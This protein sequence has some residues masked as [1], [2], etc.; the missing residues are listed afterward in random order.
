MAYTAFTEPA[1][2]MA[3]YSAIP[4]RV[5]SPNVAT[6]ENFKY[7]INVIY[8]A[9]TISAD[10]AVGFGPNTFTQLEFSSPHGYQN[11]QALFLDDGNDSQTGYYNIVSL[12]TINDAII[13]LNYTIGLLGNADTYRF[14]PFEISADLEG[15]AK[16]DL[17]NTLRD[18]VTENLEDVNEAFAG[19]DTA[20]CYDIKA[21]E[22]SNF[23]FT[24]EDNGAFTGQSGNIGFFNSTLSA[25][26]ITDTLP[27]KV[28]DQVIVEQDLAEWEYDDSVDAGGDNISFTATTNIQNF[29][30]GQTVT[31]TGQLTNPSYNG[32]VIVDAI[33]DL[34]SLTI[35]KAQLDPAPTEG[36]SIFGVPR[37]EYNGTFTIQDIFFLAGFGVVIVVDN[38][39][40]DATQPISGTIKLID[41]QT[42][43]SF[44]EITLL[45]K[46]I[47]NAHTDRVDYGFDLETF[48]PFV[49]K[50]SR[51]AAENNTS[52]ILS[53][54]TRFRI[55][56]STKSWLLHHIETADW[57]SDVKFT[58][59]DINENEL[60]QSLLFN[61][62]GN[63]FD[64]YFPVGLDQVN[65]SI[66]RI[67]V[68]ADLSA[69]T[70]SINH[71]KVQGIETVV[72]SAVTTNPI[73]FELN[74]DCSRFELFHLMWKDK[75]GSWLSYPFK[76]ISEDTT[77]IERKD[78]Y[79]T[80]GRFDLVDNTFG[81][82]SFEKGQKTFFIRTRDK[83]KLNTGW[84]EEFE[85]D[86][87]KD[88]M[89][90]PAVYVQLPDDTLLPANIVNKDIKLSKI[91]SDYLWN[92]T[93]DIVI[94]YNE[95][96][97]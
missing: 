53:G 37:P 17:S 72:A 66:N 8:S 23:V 94:S 9:Q 82:D 84:V 63:R 43:T 76:Y 49:I 36:G 89:S 91:E 67:D 38:P 85:N 52:T 41:D 3:G 44:E 31:V 59:F 32:D 42:S 20:F 26:Y 18:F 88:L 87:M 16:L 69:I 54:T 77:E 70:S 10:T 73:W 1:Q 86:L 21:G 40:T 29:R 93:F 46:C 50:A 55:E 65:A 19:P 81:Y 45:N 71:Y 56:Q 33:I 97:F 28:G 60:G 61:V 79:R 7:V 68:T 30:T 39:V 47:F 24:F 83:H 90:S 25:A 5:N 34:N 6:S 13:N 96:R 62:T 22:K 64:Y 12:P 48:D 35:N 14:L 80:E 95:N 2:Y 15:E 74:D 11:G 27:F 4:L 92:F 78:Y 57:G 58:W 75:R 51:L